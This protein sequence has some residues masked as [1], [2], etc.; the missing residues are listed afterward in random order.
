M[1]WMKIG[2][3]ILLGAMLVYLFP[4]ARH[5]LGSSPEGSSDDWKSFAF[6]ILGVALFVFLLTKLV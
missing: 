1:D 2:G 4:R 3:A 6:L 5:M